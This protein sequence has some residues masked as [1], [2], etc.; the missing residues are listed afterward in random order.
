MC[1]ISDCPCGTLS[2]CHCLVADM[3]KA[4]LTLLPEENYMLL[5]YIFIHCQMILQN[6]DK[7]KMSMAALGLILQATL[8]VSQALVRI[9]LL[10][11]SDMILMKYHSPS[12]SC[13]LKEFV[14]L[15]ISIKI[16]T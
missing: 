8:N 1:F 6:S 10:N 14:F 12:V 11:A 16:R 3:L 2:P 13:H 5:A 4:Q 9:F 7:N 15:K